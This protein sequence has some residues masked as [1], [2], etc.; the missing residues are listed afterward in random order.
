MTSFI[1]PLGI[2]PLVGLAR[3]LSILLTLSKNQL[4]VLLILCIVLF[5]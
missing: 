4:L 1:V 5:G 3:D 2:G